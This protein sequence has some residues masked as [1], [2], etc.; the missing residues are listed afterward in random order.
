MFFERGTQSSTRH[1]RLRYLLLFSLR[2]A[3][4]LLL[5]LAFANPF[6][7]LA[8]RGK[9]G[10]TAAGGGRQLFQHEGGSA[11]RGAKQGALQVAG[12]EAA[13]T[14]CRSDGFGR[15]AR[16][17][18]PAYSGCRGSAFRRSRVSSPEIRARI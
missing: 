17:V 1:R 11:L 7:R 12:V 8:E 3:L 10:T 2:A 9:N 15:P 13:G 5:V 6:I 18:D 16:R 14:A 4:L